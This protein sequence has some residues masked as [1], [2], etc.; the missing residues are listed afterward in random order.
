MQAFAGE[1]GLCGVENLL[2]AA[3]QVCIADSGH[4]PKLKRIFVLNKLTMPCQP[5]P[6]RCEFV[7]ARRDSGWSA[8]RGA[9]FAAGAEDF[10]GVADIGESVLG[11]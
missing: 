8:L 11:G 7:W 9:A 10:H 2:S 3:F 1:A 4:A 5:C 6:I